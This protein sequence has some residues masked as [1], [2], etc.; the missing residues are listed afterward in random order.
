MITNG[1]DANFGL[2]SSALPDVSGGVMSFLQPVSIGVVQKQQI[3]G[4]TEEIIKYTSTFACRQPMPEAMAVRKDGERSWKWSIIHITPE[5][6]LLTD[7]VFLLYG[8]RY[9]IMQINDW[10]EYGYKEMHVIADYK[11]E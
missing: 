9:R 7:D 3:D 8:V 6:A 5:L 11:D 2:A 10:T 1:K 4:Y